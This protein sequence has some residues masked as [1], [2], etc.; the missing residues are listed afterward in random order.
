MTKQIFDIKK[1]INSAAPRPGFELTEEQMERLRRVGE[2]ALGI[3]IVAGVAAVSVVAPNIF[4]ALD[5]IFGKKEYGTRKDTL[6]KRREQ[7]TKSFYYMRRQGY[8]KIEKR[9]ELLIVQPTEKGQ[10]RLAKLQFE[11]LLVRRPRLWK[12]TWWLVLADIPS[13]PFRIAA[14]MFQKKLKQ[15]DFYP[16]QRT[17]WVHPFDP[18]EEVESVAAHYRINPFVTT[19]EVKRLDESDEEALR[20]FFQKKRLI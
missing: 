13:K 4:T 10:R 9:G 3:T 15:M 5:K 1:E 19:M 11:N 16:L 18:R 8:I 14:D 2:V 17:A 12:G 20:D 6:A 7:L